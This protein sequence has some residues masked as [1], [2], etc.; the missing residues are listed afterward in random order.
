[1]LRAPRHGERCRRASAVSGSCRGTSLGCGWREWCR[2]LRRW[3]RP[4]CAD[5]MARAR[6]KSGSSAH[7][8]ERRL[9]DLADA[10]G[11]DADAL[12]ELSQRALR[13]GQAEA[14]FDHHP[15]ALARM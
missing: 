2:L 6:R 11:A 1:M 5:A 3:A 7:L 8:L 14:G 10:L 13:A 9:L 12:A 15:L 4:S